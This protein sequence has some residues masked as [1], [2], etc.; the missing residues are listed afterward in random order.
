LT[1]SRHARHQSIT[2]SVPI[3]GVDHFAWCAAKMREPMSTLGW[4]G[5]V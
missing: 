1:R 2:N 3:P 5:N 4:Q